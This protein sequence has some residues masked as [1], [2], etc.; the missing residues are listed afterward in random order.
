MDCQFAAPR[1]MQTVEKIQQ[2]LNI[3]FSDSFQ[4]LQD[5]VDVVMEMFRI[6]WSWLLS[7]MVVSKFCKTEEKCRLLKQIT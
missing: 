5:Q 7:H 6:L 4:F 3:V 1:R 2:R